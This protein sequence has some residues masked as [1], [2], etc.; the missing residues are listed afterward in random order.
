[1][2]SDVGPAEADIRVQ[3]DPRDE[4]EIIQWSGITASFASLW[5]CHEFI[6]RMTDDKSRICPLPSAISYQH[7]FICHP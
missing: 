5:K 6:T 1:M 4:I 3:A 2:A 7:A